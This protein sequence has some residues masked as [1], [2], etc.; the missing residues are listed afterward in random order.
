M[1]DSAVKQRLKRKDELSESQLRHLISVSEGAQR[2]ARL[3][4]CASTKNVHT[5]P[6][7]QMTDAE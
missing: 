3:P 2:I 1:F 5:D 4:P 6:Y 7:A